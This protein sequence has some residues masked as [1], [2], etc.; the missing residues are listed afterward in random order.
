[1]K[2]DVKRKMM[3]QSELIHVPKSPL[4]AAAKKKTFFRAFRSES[5]HAKPVIHATIARILH[6]KPN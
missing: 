4:M 1:M 6:E 3:S 5:T 2:N